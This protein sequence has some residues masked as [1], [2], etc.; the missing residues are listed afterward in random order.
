MKVLFNSQA[1]LQRSKDG[2]KHRDFP[3]NL[4][5]VVSI[6]IHF[7]ELLSQVQTQNTHLQRQ[8]KVGRYRV[9]P[10]KISKAFTKTA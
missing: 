8:G 6:F 5:P 9:V 7:T 2:R 3:S 4:Q 10:R 1:D